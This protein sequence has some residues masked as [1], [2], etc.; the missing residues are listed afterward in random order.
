MK[1]R[2]GKKKGKRERKGQKE[3]E[4]EEPWISQM[5]TVTLAKYGDKY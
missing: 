5:L 1:E 3:K 2:N 4:R